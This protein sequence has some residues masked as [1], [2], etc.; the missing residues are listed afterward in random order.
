MAL[1]RYRPLTRDP[2]RSRLLSGPDA[3]RPASSAAAPLVTQHALDG[4]QDRIV[5]RFRG[6]GRGPGVRDELTNA[7]EL[8]QVLQRIVEMDRLPLG[9]TIAP[10]PA[11]VRGEELGE[12]A[13]VIAVEPAEVEGHQDRLDG[14][15]G[16]GL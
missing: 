5:R 13:D 9:V 8:F 10:E 2:A 12:A 4:V 6:G 1:T 3:D 15:R 11:D 14:D 16:Q 7:I